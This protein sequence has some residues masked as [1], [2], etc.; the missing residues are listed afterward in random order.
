ML[1]LTARH[2]QDLPESKATVLTL[3]DRVLGLGG[4]SCGPIPLERDIVRSGPWRFGFT[5]LRLQAGDDASELGKLDVPVTSPVLI[6]R[7]RS[8]KVRF[9][10]GT[11]KA[12]I[13]YRIDGGAWQ[14]WSAPFAVK[15]ACKVEARAKA[16]GM[17][18]SAVSSR[19]FPFVLSRDTCRNSFDTSLP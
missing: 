9:D 6:E 17:I 19:D 16:M 7:D 3:S 12:E 4:A 14:K 10:S 18:E 5:I 13:E 11:P 1:L 8:G 15:T 2:P